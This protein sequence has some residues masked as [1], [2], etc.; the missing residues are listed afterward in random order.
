MA[1]WKSMQ[2]WVCFAENGKLNG[3][4]L[5][6][7]SWARR[8]RDVAVPK[9]I[10]ALELIIDLLEDG[11]GL[12]I[13]QP[14]GQQGR[15]ITTRQQDHGVLIDG[16]RYPEVAATLIRRMRE[17]IAVLVTQEQQQSAEAAAEADNW[18]A[19]DRVRGADDRTRSESIHTL[20]GGLPTLG[21][22]R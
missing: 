1:S 13:A 16:S 7:T 20:Q 5:E 22:R 14:E 15:L 17:V 9:K 18:L 2:V 11:K 8:K 10:D 6:P 21:R 12:R 3:A 19:G 4:S